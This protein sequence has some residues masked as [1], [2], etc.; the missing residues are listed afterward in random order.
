MAV[1]KTIMFLYVE[2]LERKICRLV[3]YMYICIYVIFTICIVYIIY[4]CN[5]KII[6]PSGCHKHGFMAISASRITHKVI[7]S[8]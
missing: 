7:K 2:T 5:Y 4:K 3:L 1:L 8:L 6:Y